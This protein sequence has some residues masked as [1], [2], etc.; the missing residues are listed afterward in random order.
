[1][2]N[3]Q[4]VYIHNDIT[5]N[6]NYNLSLTL[7]KYVRCWEKVPH[8]LV[9]KCICLNKS[10]CKTPFETIMD[11]WKWTNIGMPLR[12]VCYPVQQW[13]GQS[14]PTCRRLGNKQLGSRSEGPLLELLAN[15]VPENP[16]YYRWSSWLEFDRKTPLLSRAWWHTPLIPALG[17]QRQV[18]FWVQ[19]QPGL[20]SEF[21]DS[22]G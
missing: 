8:L 20:Q 22:Q 19:G 5:Q 10:S 14:P 11:I 13:T 15:E 17:R 1:M 12:N 2:K 3:P 16:K 4:I 21:Q 18:D 6:T 9:L 7:A